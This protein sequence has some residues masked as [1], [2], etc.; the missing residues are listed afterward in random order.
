VTRADDL[1]AALHLKASSFWGPQRLVEVMRVNAPKP[2]AVVP[3]DPAWPATFEALREVYVAAL[4]GI[5]AAVEH[6]GS[7]SVPNLAAKPI[8]DIDVVIPSIVDV[9]E[10]VRRLGV[11]GYRH[12]GDLGVPGREAFTR[13]GARDVPRS[14]RGRLWP[15]HHLYLCA[16]G[17]RE[18][19]RHLEFRDALR[20]DPIAAASYGALKIAL[21]AK[22]RDDRERYTD[23]KTD[24]IEGILE[25]TSRQPFA[26]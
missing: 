2:V 17:S 5:A 3:Y 11:L 24:F 15:D 21:A 26:V 16:A 1:L 19:R 6:V 22:F 13:D 10:A 14:G 9:A 12:Q 4:G 7:T 23:G 25:R 8:I 18:L 20:A